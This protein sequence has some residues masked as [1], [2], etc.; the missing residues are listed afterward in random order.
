[1]VDAINA[2][3]RPSIVVDVSDLLWVE[4]RLSERG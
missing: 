2:E 1:M 3:N 4:V